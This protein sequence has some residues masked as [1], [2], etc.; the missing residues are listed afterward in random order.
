MAVFTFLESYDF[1]GKTIYPLITH[2]GN[3]FGRSL[4]DLKKLCPRAVIGEGLSIGAFDKPQGQ[5]AGK[6]T[7]QGSYVMAS[8]DWNN[9]TMN[10]KLAARLILD[11]TFIVLLLCALAYRITGDIAHEWV[12][13]CVCTVCI[14]HNTLNWK[15]YANIFRGTYTLRRGVMTA[16][17]LLL[18]IAMITLIITGLL[19]SRTVLYLFLTARSVL[20]LS[21]LSYLYLGSVF[22][23][24]EDRS[25]IESGKKGIR[26]L[27]RASSTTSVL[28]K[29]PKHILNKM[30]LLIQLCVISP[31]HLPTTLGRNNYLN[32]FCTG[33]VYYMVHVIPSIG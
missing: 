30:A 27:S 5:H 8:Q 1:S 15:W 3:C 13:V 28:L 33:C 2:G 17:N 19:H 31:Y 18:A 29:P 16:V 20:S 32:T 22:K 25:E 14:A 6:R 12:G 4:D 24:K 9:G 21:G 11:F 10:K 23:R 7:E 26:M